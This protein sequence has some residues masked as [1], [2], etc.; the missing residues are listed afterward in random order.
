MLDDLK[1]NAISKIQSTRDLIEL[2]K[3]KAEFVGKTSVLNQELQKLSKLPAEEKKS[4]GKQIND[5]KIILQ[6]EIDKRFSDLEQIELEKSLREK[7]VDVTVPPRKRRQGSIHPIS[8]CMEELIYI[9]SKYGFGVQTGP[10]IED[11]WHNFSALNIP[12]SHPAR[13]MHDSFY[14]NA[15]D[16]DGKHKLL[17]THT[18]PI[19]I[20]ACLNS[21]DFPMQFVAPGR[22]YRSD[23]DATHTPMFHQIEGL[24]IDKNV[25]MGNLKYIIVNFI[26]DFFENPKIEFRFRPSFFP[27]TEPSAEVDIRMPGSQKWLEVLGCGMIHPTVLKNIN[28]NHEEYS[29]FAFG[30]GVERFAM[31]KY[32]ISDL[33]Q[34]FESD[35]NWLD[36]YSFR[37]FDV[38]NILGR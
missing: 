13:Q 21:A 12:E 14:L 10:D 18:S 5:L 9:F 25:T 8:M 7:Q 11:Q 32:N 3:I 2:Q 23:S 35:K 37:A 16:E 15:K 6:E 22:T 29:G 24:L 20:R 4:F 28:I 38:I 17:R 36:H 26:K 34:F 1:N 27:F 30:L 19:Q 33:R 31:L